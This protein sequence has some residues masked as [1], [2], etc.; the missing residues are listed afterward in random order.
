M[1]ALSL[2]FYLAPSPADR[3]RRRTGVRSASHMEPHGN[4]ANT[5]E[6]VVLV[7][8]SEERFRAKHFFSPI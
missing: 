3:N 7:A 6:K 4:S 2:G 8:L 5:V 1:T